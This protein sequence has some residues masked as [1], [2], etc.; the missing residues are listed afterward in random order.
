MLNTASTLAKAAYS[1]FTV[2]FDCE[3]GA[4][5]QRSEI[6]LADIEQEMQRNGQIQPKQLLCNLW[7]ALQ[8]L[9]SFPD[10][11]YILKHEINQLNR[12]TIYGKSDEA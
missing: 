9:I 4:I 8:Q 3:S 12:V 10:G 1:H 2:R 5:L 7:N 6:S 11:D